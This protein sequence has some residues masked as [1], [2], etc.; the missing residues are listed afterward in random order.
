MRLKSCGEGVGLW[1]GLPI[2]DGA[3]LIPVDFMKSL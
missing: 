2:L 1:R 3:R